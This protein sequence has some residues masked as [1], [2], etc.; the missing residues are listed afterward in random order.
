MRTLYHW[1]LDPASRQ[2]RIALTE[3]KVKFTLKPINPWAPEDGFLTTVPEAMPPALVEQTPSGGTAVISGARA[4][5]EYAHDG[6]ARVQLLPAEPLERAEARRLC[7][8]FD[9]KFA[10]EV[11][12]YILHEKVEKAMTRAGRPETAVLREG[13]EALGYHLDYIEDLIAQRDWLVGR[14]MSLADIAGGAHI[15]CLDFLGEIKWR[16][17]RTLKGWYQRFK[18][19]PSVQPLLK[20]RIP[21]IYAPGWYDDLDF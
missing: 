17:R 11:E 9:N 19:R 1:P 18:S 15:S 2:A 12:S 3:A 21:G 6:A 16:E 20:D 4:I 5:C 8:W 14:R 7:D 10:V 13:R